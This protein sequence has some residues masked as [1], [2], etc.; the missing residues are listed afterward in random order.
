[1]DIYFSSN[2]SIIMVA[3]LYQFEWE[4]PTG[5][6]DDCFQSAPAPIKGRP[7][8]SAIK[9]GKTCRSFGACAFLDAIVYPS[10]YHIGWLLYQIHQK[11]LTWIRAAHPLFVCNDKILKAPVIFP[12]LG[13]KVQ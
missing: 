7:Y 5:S 6:G 3:E 1:M 12:L 13:L 11:V 8:G 10:P 4:P 2:F 9:E